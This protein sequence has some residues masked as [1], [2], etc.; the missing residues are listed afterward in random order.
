M[1]RFQKLALLTATATY[2]LVVWGGVVRVTAPA[3]LP[4]LAVVLR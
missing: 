1:T 2:V 3:W 4:G